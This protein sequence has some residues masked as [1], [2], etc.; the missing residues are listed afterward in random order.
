MIRPAIV[1]SGITDVGGELGIFVH[2][3]IPVQPEQLVQPL[4]IGS[5]VGGELVAVVFVGSLL[6]ESGDVKHEQRWERNDRPKNEDIWKHVGDYPDTKGV[7]RSRHVCIDA[8]NGLERERR[9]GRSGPSNGRSDF[10]W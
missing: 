5:R 8:W 2:R 7:A 10:G 9:T 6:C 1:Q 4:T 3:V